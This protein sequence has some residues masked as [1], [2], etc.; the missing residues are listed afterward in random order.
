MAAGVF[1]AFLIAVVVVF[2]QPGA[3]ERASSSAPPPPQ[4]ARPAAPTPAVKSDAVK[5]AGAP[6]SLPN[7]A[8]PLVAVAAAPAPAPKPAAAAPRPSV[9][10]IVAGPGRPPVRDPWSEP[11]PSELKRV[12]ELALNG[13][14][15]NEDNI[16]MLR[17]YNRDHRGDVRGHLL[18]ASLFAN[19][20]WRTDAA[21]ELQIALEKDVTARGAPEVLPTLLDMVAQGKAGPVAEKV[22]LK[23]YG[24]EALDSIEAAFDDVKK[25]NDAA[26]LHSLRLK[27]TG[28]APPPE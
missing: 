24:K 20:L 7:Q 28:G 9:P 1:G 26:R 14:P 15:G 16:K 4:A 17:E 10:S 12:R 21:E 3:S 2:L 8:P 25:A 23:A 6:V 18:I 13:A 27:I 19:R 22:I 11:L 5:P